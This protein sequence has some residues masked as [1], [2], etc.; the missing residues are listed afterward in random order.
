MST[1][2][3][4]IAY[5][6]L[7]VGEILQSGDEVQRGTTWE[8]TIRK[9]GEVLGISKYRR[10]IFIPYETLDLGTVIEEGDEVL[11]SNGMEAFVPEAF[12]KPALNSSRRPFLRA[13]EK[14]VLRNKRVV[15]LEKN[16]QRHSGTHPWRAWDNLILPD[17]RGATHLE[18]TEVCSDD[19][20]GRILKV[21]ERLKEGDMVDTSSTGWRILGRFAVGKA[22]QPGGSFSYPE[23]LYMRPNPSV[24]EWEEPVEETK[25][26]AETETQSE[27]QDI[28]DA[29]NKDT[30]GYKA[31]ID[32][33]EAETE[34]LH[35]LWH[36]AE[37]KAKILEVEKKVMIEAKGFIV[38]GPSDDLSAVNKIVCENARLKSDNE[39]QYNDLFSYGKF[40]TAIAE[41]L[42]ESTL[43]IPFSD[44]VAA[45]KALK[46]ENEKLRAANIECS[47][48]ASVEAT[49]KH[50][51]KSE[52][53][54]WRKVAE[55]L[56][57]TSRSGEEPEAPTRQDFMPEARQLAAQ[58]WCD[59]ETKNT[60]MDTA[61][62]EAVA[63]RIAGWMGIAAQ[64]SRNEDFYLGVVHQ[65]GDMFGLRAKV[66][67]DG[68]I[69]Q[70]VLTLKVPELVAELIIKSEKL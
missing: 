43:S 59:E 4:A 2:N 54:S 68:S 46:S 16:S 27:A 17:G 36:E 70:D 34:R 58:C 28:R 3:K 11:T 30:K 24:Q 67:D 56:R 7:K 61:L 37:E 14:Y 23:G 55:D 20:M 48:F 57:Y 52:A 63:R 49:E 29:W 26:S 21:G 32:K 42:G 53:E 60:V 15:T 65:I 40:T 25:S 45:V 5:R 6:E 69:C 13:G 22:V 47:R 41:A 44:T 31:Q 62:A 38:V 35:G 19:I 64:F 9:A 39:R 1:N 66:A 18:S 12:G 50:Q 33:L 10:P 51:W 8:P